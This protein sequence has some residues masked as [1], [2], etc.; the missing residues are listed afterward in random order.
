MVIIEKRKVNDAG[1]VCCSVRFFTRLGCFMAIAHGSEP[2]C[3]I[4]PCLPVPSIAPYK[5]T[6]FS[7][8]C[9]EAGSF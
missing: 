7:E 6:V 1:L 5:W 2:D 4:C 9:C 3:L 8:L